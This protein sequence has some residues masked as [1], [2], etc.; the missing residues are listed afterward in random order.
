MKTNSAARWMVKIRVI[1]MWVAVAG[2]ASVEFR[3]SE[4]LASRVPQ[5]SARASAAPMA[6]PVD[7]GYVL[8]L[9]AR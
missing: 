7:L 9:T 5:A 3:A 1:M 4:L 8:D 6:P 2:L